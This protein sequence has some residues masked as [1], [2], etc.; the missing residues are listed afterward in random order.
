M[1]LIIG[2]GLSGLLTAY[3]LKQAG[4]PFKIIEARHRI[5]GRIHTVTGSQPIPVE[6]GATWFN[7]SH[8]NLLQLLDELGLDYFEQYMEGTVFYQPDVNAPVQSIQIPKQAPS[9]RISKGSSHL[10]EVLNSKISP[11]DIV[12]DA[13]VTKI[14]FGE[15]SVQ[16]TADKT[17]QGTQ[18]VLALP[19]KLWAKNITFEPTLPQQL[20]KIGKETHTWME[21]SIKVALTYKMPFWQDKKQSGALFSNAG[22]MT[23]LYDHC[24]HERSTYALCGFMS[25]SFKSLE[26][27]ARKQKVIEQL[28]NAFG[29]VATDFIDYHE[30]IWSHEEHTF[31][32]SESL[33]FPHQNNGN[34]IFRTTYFD[35]RLFISSSESATEFAGYMDGAVAAGNRVGNE[36]IKKEMGTTR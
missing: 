29:T 6:M 1:I 5:G 9:Y 26:A 10:I 32:T 27:A 18:V 30:S 33:L 4:I 8:H 36:I 14:S 21:D 35:H 7:D 19:P 12:F 25:T 3:R 28:Q 20:I 22:P 31:A 15:N 16:V 2:A 13:K 23:E 11:D 17:F 34:S 24:N